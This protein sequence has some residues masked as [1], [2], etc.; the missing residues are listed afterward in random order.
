MS[1]PSPHLH[2]SHHYE[3]WYFNARGR[4]EP[5]RMMFVVSG[6]EY[7]DHR[8]KR[9]DWT[10]VKA[11]GD[12]PF[13]QMPVLFVDG[14]PIAQTNAIMRYLAKKLD[15]SGRNDYENAQCL[16][17]AEGIGDF[18]MKMRPI[19]MEQDAEEKK[20]KIVEAQKTFIPEFL[21]TY[22]KFYVANENSAWFIGSK[23]TWADIIIYNTLESLDEQHPEVMSQFPKLNTFMTNFQTVPK[24]AEWLKNRP[25]TDF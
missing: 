21:T 16:M 15:L 25:K 24:I 8:V 14:I 4:A 1:L 22:T 11:T 23:M 5:I 6:T 20:K 9:E 12:L 3:L 18:M 17:Y 10:A 7:E 19:F 13:G 2:H